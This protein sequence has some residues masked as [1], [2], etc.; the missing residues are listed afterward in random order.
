M[1]VLGKTT[2]KVLREALARKR[3]A[4]ARCKVTVERAVD[5]YA[6]VVS[7]QSALSFRRWAVTVRIASRLD[8]LFTSSWGIYRW[9][10][11]QKAKQ[12]AQKQL[13]HRVGLM[14]FKGNRWR[15][16]GLRAQLGARKLTGTLAHL[17]RRVEVTSLR[18]AFEWLRVAVVK[19]AVRNDLQERTGGN[20]SSTPGVNEF[21]RSVSDG[22]KSKKVLRLPT[23]SPP[24]VNSF[25]VPRRQAAPPIAS[26]N[27]LTSTFSQTDAYSVLHSALRSK[28][29]GVGSGVHKYKHLS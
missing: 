25:I 11:A 21:L 5:Y 10:L 28:T 7:R 22:E 15:R 16:R 24:P 2:F 8:Y 3:L 27:N 18:I 9:K 6:T 1:V 23:Y 13:F 12:F 29:T 17:C 20:V 4:W 26:V 14:L 19:G